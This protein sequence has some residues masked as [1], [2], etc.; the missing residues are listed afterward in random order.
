[1]AEVLI[2]DC[3]RIALRPLRRSD[4]PSIAAL[5]GDKS[6]ATRTASIPYPYTLEDAQAW[7][8]QRLESDIHDHEI[9]LVLERRTDGALLG[10]AGLILRD[11]GDPPSV[12]FWLGRP[13]W[14]QG[15]MTEAVRRL[16]DYAFDELG[17]DAVWAEAFPDNAASIR[18]QEKL[19]MTY[20]GRAVQAAPARGGDREV[21]VREIRR[22]SW[23]A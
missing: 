4:A 8:D 12:G 18:V 23:R 15:Y 2:L 17:A 11:G 7:V 14:N 5:A 13:F 6:V 16:L 3:D 20:V 19:G 10:A 9:V 21:E 22:E 1:M